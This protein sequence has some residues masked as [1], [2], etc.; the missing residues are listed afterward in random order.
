MD[1]Q[2]LNERIEAA[3]QSPEY[4]QEFADLTSPEENWRRIDKDMKVPSHIGLGAD[5]CPS[6]FESIRLIFDKYSTV[7][8]EVEIKCPFCKADLICKIEFTGYTSEV[9]LEEA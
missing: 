5:D 6:C 7:N 1:T 3:L 2:E 8:H 4:I 9:Y